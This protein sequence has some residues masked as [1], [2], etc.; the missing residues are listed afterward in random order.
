MEQQRLILLNWSIDADYVLDLHC[1][2]HAIMHL[3][4]SPARP[5]DTSLLCKCVGAELA[6]IQEVSGG[7]AFDEAHTASWAALKHLYAG[8]FPVPNG[9]FSAT[10]EYRGQFDVSDALA[11]SDAKNLT[12]FLA[13]IGAIEATPDKPA[14]ADPPHYP[15]GGSVEA[16]APQGGVVTWTA[17]L[18]ATV[19]KDQ[20]LAYV[21]NPETGVRL[22]VLAPTTGILFRQELWR[23]CLR[24][25]GLCHVAGPEVVLGGHLLSD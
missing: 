20:V 4:A 8:R 16:F 17:A 24:G 21:T 25:Q 7:N 22:P 5:H 9:C 11:A 10:L 6:L 18:G 19:K 2:H 14:F 15:L 3:Y 23:S 12:I 1:D 13:H